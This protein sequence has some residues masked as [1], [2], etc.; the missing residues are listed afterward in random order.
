MLW[1]M[2]RQQDMNEDES[3]RRGLPKSDRTPLF[4]KEGW[5]EIF[6]RAEVPYKKTA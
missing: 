5:G 6:Q 3:H 2:T 4:D 1:S